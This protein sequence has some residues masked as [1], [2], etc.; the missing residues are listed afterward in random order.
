MKHILRKWDLS[1]RFAAA[2]GNSD[3]AAL[4]GLWHDLGKYSE[5]FQK[6]TRSVTGY[7]P[8]AHLEENPGLAQR[9]NRTGHTKPS[10]T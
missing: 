5:A 8:E 10:V 1:G 6:R 3:W 4:A 7:D 2:F 9:E